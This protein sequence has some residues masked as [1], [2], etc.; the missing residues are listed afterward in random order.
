M[1]TKRIRIAIGITELGEW[2]SFAQDWRSAS[3]CE[4]EARGYNHPSGKHSHLVWIEADIPLPPK[5]FIEAEVVTMEK[6]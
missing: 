1:E 5:T 3:D 6:Q 4:Y 2:I